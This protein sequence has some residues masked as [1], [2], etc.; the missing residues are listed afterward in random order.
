MCKVKQILCTNCK[1]IVHWTCTDVYHEDHE[2]EFSKLFC[3]VKVL[4][5]TQWF[6]NISL[7]RNILIK[8]YR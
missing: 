1:I 5:N 7:C 3:P 6:K 8:P 4:K 2:S